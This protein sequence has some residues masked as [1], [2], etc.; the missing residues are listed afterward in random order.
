MLGE[1]PEPDQRSGKQWLAIAAGSLG[2]TGM[3]LALAMVVGT[4]GFEQRRSSLHRGRLERLVDRAPSVDRVEAG[5]A[6]EGTHLVASADSPTELQALADRWGGD[7]AAEIVEKG[8]RW[9][10]TRAFGAEGY[11]YVLYFDDHGV[12]QDFTCVPR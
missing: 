1:E 10:S 9:G 8:S 3:A 7:D 4:W 6:A 2:V 5:L 11:V 12:L